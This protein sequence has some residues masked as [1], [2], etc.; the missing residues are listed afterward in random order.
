MG[1]L[2]VIHS[3]TGFPEKQTL[4][5]LTT[6]SGRRGKKAESGEEGEEKVGL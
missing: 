3:Q 6:T 2:N 5:V 4:R 1:I